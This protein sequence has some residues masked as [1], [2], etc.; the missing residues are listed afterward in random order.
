M[1]N[2]NSLSM[3]LPVYKIC[4]AGGSIW[5]SG[6]SSGF[7]DIENFRLLS[8]VCKAHSLSPG[9]AAANDLTYSVSVGSNCISVELVIDRYQSINLKFI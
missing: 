9:P 5:R 1:T 8:G 6:F 3:R 2:Q 7:N 4:L